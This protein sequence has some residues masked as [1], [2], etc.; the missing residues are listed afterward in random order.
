LG[1]IQ[2]A[3]LLALLANET[4]GI[5]LAS[6]SFLDFER[7]LVMAT[8]ITLLNTF[9][10]GF[11][12]FGASI[13]SSNQVVFDLEL[14]R[15]RPIAE[16]AIDGNCKP[17]THHSAYQPVQI[18]SVAKISRPTLISIADFAAIAPASRFGVLL[19]GRDN[20]ACIMPSASL[21]SLYCIWLN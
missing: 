7:N 20:L 2:T 3:A 15:A 9:T 11:L 18:V 10:L 1:V 19:L 6:V 4:A 17:G 14:L 8:L 13:T 16:M 12:G 21:Q 5:I